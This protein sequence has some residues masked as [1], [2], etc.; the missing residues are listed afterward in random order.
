MIFTY[1]GLLA[2]A[3]GSIW[4]CLKL[5]KADDVLFL[6]A[7]ATGITCFIGGVALAPWPVKLILVLILISLNRFSLTPAGQER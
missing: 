6:L 5:R 4:F 3:I 7:M 2:I 1:L